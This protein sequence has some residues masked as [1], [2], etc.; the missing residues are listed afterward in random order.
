M[1]KS[2]GVFVY[3]QCVFHQKI[4]PWHHL[5]SICIVI[6]EAGEIEMKKQIDLDAISFTI[7]KKF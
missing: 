3:L 5:L 6:I 4:L 1:Q 7:C 2:N